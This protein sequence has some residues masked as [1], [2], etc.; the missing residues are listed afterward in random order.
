VTRDMMVYR[1]PWPKAAL[2]AMGDELVRLRVTLSYFVE[3]NP[4]TRAVSSKYRYPGCNLRFQVQTPTEAR[5]SFFARVSDAVSEEERQSS[6]PASDTTDGWLIG[7]ENRR[8]GSLHSDIWTGT[9][10]DLAG[11]EHLIVY[12]VNGWWRLRPRHKRFNNRIRYSLIATVESLG[13]DIDLYAAVQ[14]QIA[15]PISV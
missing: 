14:A 3:P 6:V 9:A 4:G 13:A 12:P 15:Q 7:D 11:M 10:A 2:E 1:L 5:S 8:R